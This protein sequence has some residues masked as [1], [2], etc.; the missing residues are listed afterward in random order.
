MKRENL[1]K[2][3]KIDEQIRQ[4]EYIQLEIVKA[5]QYGCSGD[6]SIGYISY[7]NEDGYASKCEYV[8]IEITSE[9]GKMLLEK[10]LA[11]TKLDI[12]KL[13]K[14]LTDL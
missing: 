11:K 2:V 10:A 1:E 8:R 9:D 12:A 14:E 3:Y 5:M 6:A 13:E 4:I 7:L